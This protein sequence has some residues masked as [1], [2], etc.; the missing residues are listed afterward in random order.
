M[1]DFAQQMVRDHNAL[2]K[3][4]SDL[5][6][7][8]N[9]KPEGSDTSRALKSQAKGTTEKLKALNGAAFDKAYIDNEVKL[10]SVRI[11]AT[12]S[13]LIPNAKNAELK[14]ALENAAPLFHGHVQHA[15]KLQSDSGPTK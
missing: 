11:N 7:K 12:S 4:V 6:A 14:S 1:R 2:Q 15:K 10:P 5:G 3:S 9:V 8:L 13:I